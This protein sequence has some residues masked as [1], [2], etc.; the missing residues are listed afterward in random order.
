MIQKLHS[1][2][3][4][5]TTKFC[6]TSENPSIGHKIKVKLYVAESLLESIIDIRIRTTCDN[7]EYPAKTRIAK[8][9]N[10]FAIFS[11]EIPVMKKITNIRFKIYTK[12]AIYWFNSRGVFDH[13]PND[14]FDFKVIAEF[15]AP[16]WAAR[17]VFYQ[18]FP[19]RF[20]HGF[21]PGEYSDVETVREK[22]ETLYGR[23]KTYFRD[24][25]PSLKKWGE[26][27]DATSLGY[28]FYFG[29]LDGAAQKLGYLK[30]LG[31]TAIYFTPILKSPSNH[32]YDTIDYFE[33]DP[34]LGGDAAFERFMEE[35]RKAGIK[36][37][38]DAV[39]NHSGFSCEEF[40]KAQKGEEPFTRFFTF[41]DAQRKKYA[42]WLGNGNL[43]KLDYASNELREFIY[44]SDMSASTKWLREPYKI[45]GYRLDVAHMIG[46]GGSARN[47]IGILR[48]MRESFKKYNPDAFVLA[49]NFFDC[50][51]MLDG[52]SMDSVMNYHGFTFP[53]IDYF[54]G[55]D[56][57]GHPNAIDI[58]A[59]H[60][61]LMDVYAKIPGAHAN[62]MYNQLS[63]HDI[64]RHNSLLNNDIKKI[65]MAVTFQF[66][67]PG[68]PSIFYGDEIGLSGT[69]DPGCRASM[70]WDE[71][72]QNGA[73]KSAYKSLIKIRKN[74]SA[75]AY[76]G[77]KV[78]RA[79][80]GL[81][82]FFRKYMNET[83]VSCFNN[84]KSG[85]GFDIRKKEL[86]LMKSDGKLQTLFDSGEFIK[87]QHG[88]NSASPRDDKISAKLS[89]YGALI[90]K[91]R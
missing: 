9:Y 17:S 30:E 74:E 38:L 4:F 37:I 46:E 5:D 1:G 81:F 7:E 44:D 52:T 87:S 58:S 6:V 25:K 29:T 84:S 54:S 20:W 13:N 75:L 48:E 49:E 14:Y 19:D 56:H 26:T 78:L 70:E 59:F 68:I 77:M 22:F 15:N 10:G 18:I 76:G 27:P 53:V 65:L 57:R 80:G 36:V 72:K 2:L 34:V 33:V 51:D 11:G 63:S 8:R 32:R 60:D 42:C 40:K 31:I 43:P 28:E 79:H 73:L 61:W 66:S 64:S 82:C 47:N 45:D 35:A 23:R 24:I 83:I 91:L 90:F 71:K 67:F 85:V 12:N 89:P 39:Y 21:T 69:G 3:Y 62:I 86:F 41:Y 55:R 16:K 50:I 88:K